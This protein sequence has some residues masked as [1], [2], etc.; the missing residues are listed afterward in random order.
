MLIIRDGLK[1]FPLEP[2]PPAIVDPVELVLSLEKSDENKDV[3]VIVPENH[4]WQPDNQVICTSEKG[5]TI[6]HFNPLD[7]SYNILFSIWCTPYEMEQKR[8]ILK[9]ER[10]ESESSPET[11]E[12]VDELSNYKV[13][14]GGPGNLE[15]I[16]STNNV[17]IL[18]GKVLKRR[19]SQYFTYDHLLGWCVAFG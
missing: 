13:D 11:K 19:F 7:G 3:D 17:I 5:D 4:C 8:K 9:E 6:V 2:I 1:C 14:F 18:G 15:C 10:V 16:L 12:R